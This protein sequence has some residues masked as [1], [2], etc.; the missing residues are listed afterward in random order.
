MQHQPLFWDSSYAIA[1]RLMISHPNTPLDTVSL[2]DVAR[3]TIALP[4]FA[5]DPAL[6]NQELLAAIYQDWFEE[7]EGL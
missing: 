2:Q 4:E 7:K 1:R 5:D 3:W 6:V